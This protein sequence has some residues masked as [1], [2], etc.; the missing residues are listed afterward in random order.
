MST[1]QII[2]IT[3]ARNAGK[4]QL[5]RRLAEAGRQAGAQV[6]G[7]LTRHTGPHSLEVQELATG[8]GYPLTLPYASAGGIALSRFHMAPAAFARSAQALERSFPTELFFLDELGPVELERGEGWVVA[9]RLLREAAYCAAVI[10]IRPELL[11][12]GL[13][14]LPHTLYTVA[15]ITPE[16]RDVL[17]PQ[18]QGLLTACLPRVR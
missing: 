5:C 2:V 4:S 13:A 9:L 1:P 16:N 3:G 18:I 14:R 12:E 15:H 8:E 10:V 6:T 17:F 7:L 11:A